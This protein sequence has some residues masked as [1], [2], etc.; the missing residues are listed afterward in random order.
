MIACIQVDQLSA[1]SRHHRCPRCGSHLARDERL[2][3][4]GALVSLLF[5]RGFR[6]K[7]E[8]GWRGLRFS[9][10][11]FRHRK[12]RLKVAVIVVF[13]VLAAAVAVHVVLSRVGS[14]SGPA[15]DEGIQEVE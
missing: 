15:H 6:C 7:P 3:L 4:E 14:G 10:S 12:S 2:G 11:R 13:F 8:C 9:K 5:L 1:R